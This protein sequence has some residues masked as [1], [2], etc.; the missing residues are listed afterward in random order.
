VAYWIDPTATSWVFWA[1]KF[2][3]RL[4]VPWDRIRVGVWHDDGAYV[5]LCNIDTG[6]AWWGYSYD[7]ITTSGT[8][9]G[10]PGEYNVEVGYFEGAGGVMWYL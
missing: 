1:V 8:C 10:A 6:R 2:T 7:F 4:Y 3:G 9:A 5:K